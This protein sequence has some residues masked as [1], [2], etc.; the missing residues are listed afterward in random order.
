METQFFDKISADYQ[1]KLDYDDDARIDRSGVCVTF[2]LLINRICY[3][4]HLGDGRVVLCKEQG[5]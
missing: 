4:A 5:A 3:V 1:R 2:I